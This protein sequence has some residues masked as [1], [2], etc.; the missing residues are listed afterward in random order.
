MYID[1]TIYS[2]KNDCFTFKLMIFYDICARTD[3]F[4][5]ILLKVFPTMLIDLA[6]DYYYSNTSISTTLTF[7]KI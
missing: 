5:E 4:K 3:V 6:L 7:N 1:N 2:S